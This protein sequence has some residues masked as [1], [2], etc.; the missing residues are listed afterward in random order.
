MSDPVVVVFAPGFQQQHAH[1]AV[2]A[3][4]VAEQSTCGSAPNNDVV[5]CGFAHGVRLSTSLRGGAAASILEGWCRLSI[6]K[7]CSPWLTSSRGC[8]A[9]ADR[10]AG[11][12]PSASAQ[13]ACKLEATWLSP[14]YERQHT[15]PS[16]HLDPRGAWVQ[17]QGRWGAAEL[18]QRANWEAVQK[19]LRRHPAGADQ[20]W[21]LAQLEWLDHI[22]A[23]LLWNYWQQAWPA[24]LQ[25]SDAQK[26]MLAR[27]AAFQQAP[28]PEA[29][30]LGWMGTSTNWGCWCC[31]RWVISSTWCS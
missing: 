29:P 6:G 22:G 14:H 8:A 18:G 4:A 15:P 23:Q 24:R 21:D 1:I 17:L 20:G 16:P 19:A 7:A 31:G 9:L 13:K 11:A 2:C 26:A 12:E 27:I 28:A 30:T 10:R 25:A 5:E 3:Q